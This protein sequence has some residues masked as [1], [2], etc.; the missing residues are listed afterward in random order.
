[1][2]VDGMVMTRVGKENASE[3]KRVHPADK[4]VMPI[5]H[6]AEDS[7]GSHGIDQ[8]SMAQQRLAHVGDK[9]VGNDADTGHDRDVDLGMSEEPEQVLP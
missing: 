1:M 5:N 9:D 6:V 8:C 4:H 7:K 2:I 3:E